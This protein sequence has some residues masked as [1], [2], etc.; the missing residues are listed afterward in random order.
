[1]FINKKQL[2]ILMNA[3]YAILTVLFFILAFAPVVVKADV[4]K[5]LSKQFSQLSQQ[6]DDLQRAEQRLQQPQGGYYQPTSV[7]NVV[8]YLDEARE[9][10]IYGW[11]WDP[12]AGANPIQIN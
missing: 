7:R 10:G 3:K 8:G 5:D 2:L 11:A 6:M 9:D 4:N 1:M 12:D